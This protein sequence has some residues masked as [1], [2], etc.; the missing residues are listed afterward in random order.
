M[1]LKS[2]KN[3][4]FPIFETKNVW[5]TQKSKEFLLLTTKHID[6]WVERKVFTPEDYFSIL[7][8]LLYKPGFLNID[9]YE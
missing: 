8:T 2:L 9:I 1:L 5:V 4:S 6:P 3:Q 7:K